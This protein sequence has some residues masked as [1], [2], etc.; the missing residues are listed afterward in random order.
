MLRCGKMFE[1]QINLSS[2]RYTSSSTA[3]RYFLEILSD[4]DAADQR[5]FLRFVTGSPRLRPGGLSALQ[6]RHASASYHCPAAISSM[7]STAKIPLCLSGASGMLLTS[8]CSHYYG[9]ILDKCYGLIIL[10]KCIISPICV[11]CAD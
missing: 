10:D 11:L 3:I 7:V 1:C 6:P 9:F 8:H 2:H 5:R 4:L